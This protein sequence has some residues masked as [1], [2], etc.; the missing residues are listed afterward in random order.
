MNG[1]KKTLISMAALLVVLSCFLKFALRGYSFLALAVA[2][3]AAA[4]FLL[5]V[6]PKK[7]KA[8]LLALM[9]AF[10]AL[11]W[12]YESLVLDACSGDDPAR[13]DYL[14][15]LG[16]AVH[17]NAP[18]LSLRERLEAAE[19]FLRDHPECTAIVSGGMGPGENVSEG[20]CMKDWLVARGIDE[21]RVISEEEA[22]STEE[23]LKF[24]A[25]LIEAAEGP[26]WRELDIALC[27]S[28]YHLCRASALSEKYIG[29]RPDCVPAHTARPLLKLSNLLREGCGMIIT[30]LKR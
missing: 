22:T 1:L 12:H 23:N 7:A 25:E 24:S 29:I 8:V 27:S 9:L 15:V 13:A 11:F 5:A 20:R 3:A 2:A 10:F 16:A 17:G 19:D 21:S 14:I 6:L 30:D 18:S 28:E 4:L 26:D